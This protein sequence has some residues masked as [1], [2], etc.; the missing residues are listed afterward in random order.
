MNERT[1]VIT[2]STDG[3]PE[4]AEDLTATEILAAQKKR[5]FRPIQVNKFHVW[6]FISSP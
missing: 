6:G 4:E 3:S 1:G 2:N 5:L